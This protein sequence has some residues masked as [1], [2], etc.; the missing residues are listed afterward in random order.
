MEG[1]GEAAATKAGGD[2]WSKGVED[3]GKEALVSAPVSCA[4]TP[5]PD[6]P[7][8]AYRRVGRV[9]SEE[10]RPECARRRG[11]ARSAVKEVA[12]SIERRLY[13]AKSTG[14]IILRAERELLSGGVSAV[15]GGV[16]PE[17]FE[18]SVDPDRGVVSNLRGRKRVMKESLRRLA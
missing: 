10:S 12:V 14:A 8:K 17:R 13:A 2:V 4:I 6:E 16:R 7:A 9:R 18:G 15:D 5:Y 3:E 1:G 11:K